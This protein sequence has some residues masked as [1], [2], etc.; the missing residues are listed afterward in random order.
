MT[1]PSWD[2]TDRYLVERLIGNDDALSGTLQA[3]ADGGLPAI[4]VSP[5]QGKFLNLLARSVG[6]SRVLEIGTLGG[7]STIWLA[8]AVGQKGRVVT[9]EYRPEHATVA[10]ANLDR[11]E[12]GERVEILV[13]RALDSLPGLESEDPFDLVFIDADKENNS[14]YVNWAL[15][16]TRPGSVIVVDNVVRGGAVAQPENAEP[17]AKASRDLVDLLVAEPR[18]DA[19]VLQTVGAKGW[20]GFAY[21]LVVS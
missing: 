19:T 6:A 13:G 4:D 12:V 2:D 1:T 17:M 20:D 11:A 7:Y 8:R 10:R 18:L 3:N 9:L 21:A 15:R 14:N 16:L 5:A